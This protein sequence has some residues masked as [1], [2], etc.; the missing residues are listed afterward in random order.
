SMLIPIFLVSDQTYLINYSGDKKLL[1]LYM[2]IGNIKST[3]YNKPT[4]NT[5][6][7]ITLLPIPPK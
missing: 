3:V 7:P 1:P 5:W 6:I 2:S 4:M